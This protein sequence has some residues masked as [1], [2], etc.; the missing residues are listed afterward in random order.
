LPFGTYI[1]HVMDSMGCQGYDTVMVTEPARLDTSLFNYTFC[2]GDPHMT[3]YAPAGFSSYTWI[4]PGT[5]DTIAANSPDNYILLSNPVIGQEY[6]C[7]LNNPPGCPIYDSTYLNFNPPT[8]FFNPDSTVNVFTPNGDLKNDIF[9]PYYDYSV[10]R[11]T[12]VAGQPAYDFFDLH[13]KYYEIWIYDRWG[14]QVFYSNDYKYGWDGTVDKNKNV[15]DGVYY[16]VC[17]MTSNCTDSA[18]PIVS[19]GFVHVIR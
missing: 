6:V 8:Y 1:V 18:T 16:W 13:I 5:S 15:T 19:K 7:V 10:A 14:N 11:Q 17:Q 3:M 12:A 4:G 2:V 9:Y